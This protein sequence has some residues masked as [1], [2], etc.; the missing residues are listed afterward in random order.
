M[1]LLFKQIIRYF[2]VVMKCSFYISLLLCCCIWSVACTGPVIIEEEENSN[3]EAGKED[4]T[5]T[6][7]PVPIVHEGSYASPYSIGEAQTLG[8]GKDVWIEGYIVGAVDGSM[9]NGCQYKMP[10]TIASN[11]LLADTFPTDYENDHLYCMPVQLPDG[12]EREYLNLYDNPDNYHRKVRIQGDITLY[13]KVAGIKNI[14]DYI[15]CD[16]INNGDDNDNDNGDESKNDNDNENNE[17][18]IPDTPQDP[19]KTNTDTLS[20]AEGIKLQDEDEYIQSY[21]KGYII[22]YTTSNSTV[23]YDLNDIKKT[24]ARSNVVL[25]DNP[26]E[27]NT[28]NMIAVELKNGSYI[29]EAVNLYDNP[30]NLHRQL[31]VKGRMHPFK[32]L[33]G[34]IDIPNGYT[35]PGDTVV[36]KDYYFS[37]E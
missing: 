12:P 13:Y 5:P 4:T 18:E 3:T 35:P 24:S 16:G 15:F 7:E 2:A 6:W 11:I 25:A 1:N 33:N 17:P 10:I 37:L 22:G 29:Q 34:C 14:A 31:T 19:D 20:I 32:S 27:Q 21:I 30:E 26:E 36:I 28:N 23:Y 9:R 8:R